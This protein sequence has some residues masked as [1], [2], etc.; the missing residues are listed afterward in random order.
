[1]LISVSKEVAACIFEYSIIVAPTALQI[2]RRPLY[3][4]TIVAEADT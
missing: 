2:M 3:L 4:E 1:M